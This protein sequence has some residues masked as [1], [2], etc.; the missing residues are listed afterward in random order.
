MAGGISGGVWC[1][2]CG[3]ATNF[4]KVRL[5]GLGWIGAEIRNSPEFGSICGWRV[6][7]I[8]FRTIRTYKRN[9]M[10]V[11]TWLRMM[12]DISPS[13]VDSVVTL[14]GVRWLAGMRTLQD[15]STVH[16]ECHEDTSA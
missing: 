16:D 1:T 14:A 12:D 13:L 9:A 7:T 5:V 2:N 15:H 3:T 6:P 10:R 8:G 11:P 4:R